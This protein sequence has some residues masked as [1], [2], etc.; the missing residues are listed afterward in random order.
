MRVMKID[1]RTPIHTNDSVD[2]ILQRDR[3][4]VEQ[5]Q[6]YR[7]EFN[8]YTCRDAITGKRL[9]PVPSYARGCGL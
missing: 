3:N 4:V 9:G 1:P 6:R 2:D 8:L 7:R 5:T